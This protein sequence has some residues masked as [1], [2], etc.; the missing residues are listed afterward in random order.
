[1]HGSGA[2]QLKK[3]CSSL[4]S[5]V[6]QAFKPGV[7]RSV[8]TQLVLAE[9]IV[10]KSSRDRVILF[11]NSLRDTSC[12]IYCN[13]LKRT[14][15]RWHFKECKSLYIRSLYDTPVFRY[16]NDYD[17]SS[18]LFLHVRLY[19]RKIPYP[20]FYNVVDFCFFIHELFNSALTFLNENLFIFKVESMK[21]VSNVLRDK[22]YAFDYEIGEVCD[23]DDFITFFYSVRF[24]ILP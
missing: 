24:F 8:S 3:F 23:F 20:F 14:V 17:L 6:F 19:F 2:R 18:Y 9:N 22:V 7:K 10:C 13:L 11:R 4:V 5:Y 15:F 12:E 21:E 16:F 1:M